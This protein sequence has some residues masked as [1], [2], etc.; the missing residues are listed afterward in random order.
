MVRPRI[1]VRKANKYNAVKTKIDG[2]VFDSKKEALRYRQLSLLQTAEKI[3]ELKLQVTFKFACGAKYRADF[4]YVENGKK[5]AEDVKGYRTDVYR[6]KAKMFKHE[7][8]DFEL[9]ET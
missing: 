2:I 1:K 3:S 8:P 4:T 7:Y 6:L 9:R 5:I